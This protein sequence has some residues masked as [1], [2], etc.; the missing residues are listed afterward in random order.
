MNDLVAGVE[1][2]SHESHGFGMLEV[3]P[4]FQE[5]GNIRLESE[6]SLYQ[7]EEPNDIGSRI[8]SSN[9]VSKLMSGIHHLPKDSDVKQS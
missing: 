5:A 3:S 8:E 4:N 6:T 7:E 9:Y 1:D 2:E